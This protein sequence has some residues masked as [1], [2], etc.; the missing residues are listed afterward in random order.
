MCTSIKMHAADK[1]IIFARTMDWHSFIPE[2]LVLPQNYQWKS[3]YNNRIISNAYTILGVG[4]NIPDLHADISDGINAFG[5]SVQK[6]TF[7][8]H[9]EYA[10]YPH[11]D[12]LQ[13]APFEFVTWALGNCRSVADL[14]NQLENVQLMSDTFSHYKFGR[15]D[16]HF[17]AVDPTGRMINIEPR[18][19]SFE[20]IEN[21]IGVVTNAPKFEREIVKLQDY[22]ELTSKPLAPNRISTGDFSGKPVF[23]GGF[24]PTSRFIRATILKERA[25]LPADE[26][27]NISE[28]WH[29]LNAVTV[30]KSDGRSDTYTVYRSAVDLNSRTLYFQTYDSLSI[31]SYPFPD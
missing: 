10:E 12:K 28:V 2:A 16:L 17:S 6:L 22:M 14:I 3:A 29:I 11:E 9:S 18:N 7:S 15:S 8:N 4:R 30:P 31:I 20:I 27:Q 21:T 13:L 5:L 24:T 19:G 1:S 25:I 23:P 26:Q